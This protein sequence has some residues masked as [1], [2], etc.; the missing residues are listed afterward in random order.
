MLTRCSGRKM[1]QDSCSSRGSVRSYHTFQD[2][3]P[4]YHQ[5]ARRQGAEGPAQAGRSEE[6]SELISYNRLQP[7]DGFH[8]WPENHH[9]EGLFA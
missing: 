2:A 6:G 3:V 9:A 8:L 4:R 1:C 7:L 5:A